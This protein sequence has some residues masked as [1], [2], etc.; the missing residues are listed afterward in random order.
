[1]E[2]MSKTQTRRNANATYIRPPKIQTYNQQKL[3]EPYKQRRR[4]GAESK[5]EPKPNPD[6][7]SFFYVWIMF[8]ALLCVWGHVTRD[9]TMAQCS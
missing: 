4:P 6:D 2:H 5:F 7:R 1:M 9:L 8:A 3:N